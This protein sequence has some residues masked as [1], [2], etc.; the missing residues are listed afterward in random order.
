MAT[1]N[2][3]CE[4]QIVSQIEVNEDINDE[5]SE[6]VAILTEERLCAFYI[7]LVMLIE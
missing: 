3:F 6:S 7:R 4:G 5:T 1:Q 2:D